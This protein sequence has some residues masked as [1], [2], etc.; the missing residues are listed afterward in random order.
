M[1]LQEINLTCPVCLYNTLLQEQNKR[2]A[3][4][5]P[6]H[7]GAPS[8]GSSNIATGRTTGTP[9]SHH[10]PLTASVSSSSLLHGPSASGPGVRSTSSA[11]AAA[12]ATAANPQSL[13]RSPVA[14][15][16]FWH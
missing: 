4:L 3:A 13:H 11:V 15:S 8:S 10:P 5:R 14:S 2:L 1:S 16:D 12:A 9:L 7:T 6:N